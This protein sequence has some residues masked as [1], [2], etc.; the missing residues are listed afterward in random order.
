MKPQTMSAG[1]F[2]SEVCIL[3]GLDCTDSDEDDVI[4]AIKNLKT[5]LDIEEMVSKTNYREWQKA[6]SELDNFMDEVNNNG[7]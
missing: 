2:F 5:S 6:K 4:R 7:F 3:L 1:K